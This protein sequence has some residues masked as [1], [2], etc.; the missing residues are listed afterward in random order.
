VST[1]T[2]QFVVDTRKEPVDDAVPADEQVV[3]MPGLRHTW[4]E[5]RVSR[6]QVPFNNGDMLEVLHEHSGCKKACKPCPNYERV[7]ATAALVGA[8][9]HDA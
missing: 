9:S 7:R 5:L 4:S 3:N 2:H 6:Q 8:L 1:R